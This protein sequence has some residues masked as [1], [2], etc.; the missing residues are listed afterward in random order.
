MRG[1]LLAGGKG[2]RLSPMTD[3][4]NKHLLPV[5]DKP[6]IYYPIQTL[7]SLGCTDILIISGVEHSGHIMNLLKNGENFGINITYKVQ[8]EANGIA[9]ALKLGEDFAS[10]EPVVV[11]L[12]DNIFE[13]IP[14]TS[15]P[16]KISGAKLFLK[17]VSNPER[18]GIAE[19]DDYFNVLRIIEKPKIFLSDLAVTGLY[20][21]DSTVWDKLKL[22]RPSLRGEY[23]ITDVN[24]L[25]LAEDKLTAEILSTFWSDAGTVDSL[26]SAG[27]WVRD[28][29]NKERC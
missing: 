22:I 15:V 1:I 4:T 24:N 14:L 26:F 8:I 7:K 5:Y 23:E 27:S 29:Y 6:M 13:R 16:D 20:F 9:G 28:N 2:T 21:F 17:S 25:Y 10:K 19:V 12:G 11:I 18:F 3:V